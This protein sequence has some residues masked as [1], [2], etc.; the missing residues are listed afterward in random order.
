MLRNTK[1]V[2]S[3]LAICL[4]VV[5]MCVGGALQYFGAAHTYAA[6][7]SSK[8]D[9]LTVD[10]YKE[11][12]KQNT[13]TVGRIW[14]DK[15]VSTGEGITVNGQ[16]VKKDPNADF[17]VALSALASSGKLT[18][19]KVTPVD[20]TLLLDVSTSMKREY[21]TTRYEATYLVDEMLQTGEINKNT[22][23]VHIDGE[24]I[25]VH[26]EEAGKRKYYYMNAQGEKVYFTPKKNENQKDAVQ[27]Y[28]YRARLHELRDSA[29]K[30]VQL[31]TEENKKID[32]PKLKHRISVV[33]F[34]GD[35]TIDR[36]F[37]VPVHDGSKND[38]EEYVGTIPLRPQGETATHLAMQQAVELDKVTR[39]DAK[40]IVILF[41]DGKPHY[42][43]GTQ[44]PFVEPS[45]IAVEHAQKLKDAKAEI[46]SIGMFDKETTEKEGMVEFMETV[47]SYY[48]K[49]KLIPTKDY[50]SFTVE[51]EKDPKGAKYAQTVKE[52]T[53]LENIFIGIFGEIT[54]N[55]GYATEVELGRPDSSGYVTITD[56]LGEYMD[57]RGFDGLVFRDK[58]YKNPTKSVNGKIETYVFEG[59]IS[60]KLTEK[61]NLN[62]IIIT[63]DKTNA[64]QQVVSVK[65]P[66][67]VIP[68][69][70][71]EIMSKNDKATCEVVPDLPIRLLYSVG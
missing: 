9:P 1:K 30:F 62:K 21:D 69:Y 60:T 37:T 67:S 54:A 26:R 48:P 23:F 41:T 2:W 71:Y 47:S 50:K 14:T 40:K 55:S 38:I 52:G 4:V 29:R 24:Y 49:A 19:E 11:T 45:T 16:N 7:T 51:G 6:Y 63:V 66:A 20:I 28:C 22:L 17:Q 36:E 57:F 32:D 65:V 58:V 27:T 46:Y 64:Y 56:P 42:K 25:P 13:D 18:S 12:F 5:F 53:S 33:S 44:N 43:Q 3:K 39:K 35:A 34:T 68:V 10:N 61:T 8:A 70:W 15:S 31:V 59:E